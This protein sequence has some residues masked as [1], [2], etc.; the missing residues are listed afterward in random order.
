MTLVENETD[1]SL[2]PLAY[3]HRLLDPAK[4]LTE[5]GFKHGGTDDN[6]L[7]FWIKKLDDRIIVSV[8][9]DNQT[10]TLSYRKVRLHR[11]NKLNGPF[12]VIDAAFG[13][14][15]LEL[16]KLMAQKTEAQE[17]IHR[18]LD[19]DPDAFDP[20]AD[21]ERLVPH[22]CPECGSSNI[23][24]EA[25]DEGLLD[26]FNCGIWFNPL[27]PHNAP[28]V[29]GNFPDP[30]TVQIIDYPIGAQGNRRPPGWQPQH[31]NAEDPDAPRIEDEIRDLKAYAMQHGLSPRIT[32]TYSR[33]TPE[34][35]AEGDFS[36]TGWEDEE[37]INMA[38]DEV[39]REEGVTAAD[40]AAAYLFNEGC[41]ETSSS[42]FHPGVWYSTEWST[43]D[44]GTDEQEER[45]FHLVGFS[46]E[47]EHAVWE[48]FQALRKRSRQLR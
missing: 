10:G 29:P 47:E 3:A 17:V 9:V 12:T 1:D 42:Q 39:D 40:K 23:S 45:N 46:A 22:K 35:A 13:V 28:G 4:V 21:L 26:C 41:Y 48:K 18:L 20:R 31:E 24:D 6:D 30:S 2:D 5:L 34:S 43:I 38:P 36:D 25:D 8:N 19:N 11:P 15:V 27:D 14:P 7:D 33:T 44:F 32:I 37:G 16:R